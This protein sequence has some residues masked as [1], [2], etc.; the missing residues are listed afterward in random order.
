MKPETKTAL[1]NEL[2]KIKT[3][4]SKNVYNIAWYILIITII[5]M[6]IYL[7]P[8]NRFISGSN[9]SMFSSI[10]VLVCLLTLLF[11]SLFVII[12]YTVDKRIKILFEA[13]LEKDSE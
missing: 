8:L 5:S 1:A 7:A 9:L 13:V 6:V 3:I 10:M 11:Q 12:R 2:E 4:Q